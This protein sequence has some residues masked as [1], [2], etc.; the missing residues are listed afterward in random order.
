[1]ENSRYQKILFRCQADKLSNK[2]ISIQIF[3]AN[4]SKIH[5]I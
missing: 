2:T 1:M 4:A 5:S 3:S